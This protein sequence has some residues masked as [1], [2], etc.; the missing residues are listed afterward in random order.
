MSGSN[1][2]PLRPLPLEGLADI[3]GEM[4]Q[5]EMV[6][7]GARAPRGSSLNFDWLVELFKKYTIPMMKV[8]ERLSQE[9]FGCCI[10]RQKLVRA[11]L[12]RKD[13]TEYTAAELVDFIFNDKV[14][15]SGQRVKMLMGPSCTLYGFIPKV[16]WH[17]KNVF[18]EGATIPFMYQQQD[19]TFAY[20]TQSPEGIVPWD[21]TYPEFSLNLTTG[22]G[23][24]K[25]A[26]PEPS[27]ANG[28]SSS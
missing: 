19:G 14:F 24:G 21:G 25:D 9:G 16:D 6:P 12:L 8:Y 26:D 13:G 20:S 4:S 2:G 15:F 1:K 18:L 7:S 17:K 22:D 27:W 23:F 3:M 28:G 11:W 10:I 5:V